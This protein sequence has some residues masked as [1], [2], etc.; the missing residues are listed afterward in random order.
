MLYKAIYINYYLFGPQYPF[1]SA[2]LVRDLLTYWGMWLTGIKIIF[3]L[4][5]DEL[6]PH[7]VEGSCGNF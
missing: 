5:D 7:V 3:S 2:F 1:F 6:W 4:P